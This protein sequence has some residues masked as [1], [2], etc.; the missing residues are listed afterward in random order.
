MRAS[1]TNA[2]RWLALND[3]CGWLYGDDEYLSVAA[4]LVGDIFGKTP[5][6]VASDLHAFRDKEGLG[7]AR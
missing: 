4:A 6:K 1:Y 5:A 2:I 3:D 7:D